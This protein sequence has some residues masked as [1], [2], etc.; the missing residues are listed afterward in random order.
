M[1]N[2]MS[3]SVLSGVKIVC[4]DFYPLNYDNKVLDSKNESA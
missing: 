3:P 4:Y 1:I 2:G